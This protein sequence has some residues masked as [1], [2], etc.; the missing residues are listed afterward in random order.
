M[1]TATAPTPIVSPS[2]AR[3][4]AIAAHAL[5]VDAL[6]KGRWGLARDAVS[7]ASELLDCTG[8]VT[9][10]E[11]VNVLLTAADVE[12]AAGDP[13]AA[14][15]KAAAAVAATRTWT[16]DD[17]ELAALRLEADVALATLDVVLGDFDGAERR[18]LASLADAA[19]C[20]K[21]AVLVLVNALGVTYKLAGRLDDA[22][23]CYDEVYDL[24]QST[25]GVGPAD[26][27]VFFGNLAG[28]A[29]ARND[30]ANGIVWARRGIALRAS[31]DDGGGIDLARDYGCLG[32]LQHLA[33]RLGDAARSYELAEGV[34]AAALGPDHYE[35]GVVLANRSS[36][37]ADRGD[38]AAARRLGERAHA[39]LSAALGSDH[40]EVARGRNNLAAMAT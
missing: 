19:A 17:P 24:L 31:L 10:P 16:L 5:A 38:L 28:L 21:R 25:R 11:V 3:A 4:A 34:L 27:A 30:A 33:G 40:A 23:R 29:H 39:I 9:D 14:R 8:A 13:R 6:A 12:R 7:R 26:F 1:T 18:L 22:Q 36:L 32:A 35:T 37:E 2:T 15:A 20:S